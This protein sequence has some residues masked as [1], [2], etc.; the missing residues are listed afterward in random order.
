MVV[1]GAADVF[2]EQAGVVR[3]ARLP[4]L[5][6]LQDRSDR[7]VRAGAQCQRPCAGGIQPLGV[8]ARRQ[9][10]D[11]DAGAEPLLGMRARVQ[12]D[13]DQ[14]RSVVTDRCGLAEDSLVRPVA[15]APVRTRHVVGER[16]RRA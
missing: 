7:A 13:L 8:V 10:E 4:V 15:V 16:S 6:I 1:A 9:S 12:D 5:S 11:A 14:R 3:L 2:V